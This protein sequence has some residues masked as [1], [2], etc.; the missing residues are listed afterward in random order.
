MTSEKKQIVYLMIPRKLVVGVTSLWL[1]L[2]I[3]VLAS[4]QYTNYVARQL[5][6]VINISN[7]AYKANPNPSPT[8]QRLI[9]EFDKLN[10]HYHC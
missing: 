4:F 7:D 2:F 1:V 6:G 3:G 8:L 10:K 5:C 9:K